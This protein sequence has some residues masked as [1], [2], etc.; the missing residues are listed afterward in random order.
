MLSGKAI[1]SK[2]GENEI[3]SA[4]PSRWRTKS[5]TAVAVSVVFCLNF[6]EKKP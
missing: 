5:C 2:N 3:T 1:W 6:G 4:A